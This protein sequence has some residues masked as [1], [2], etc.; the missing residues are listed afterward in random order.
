LYSEL[1]HGGNHLQYRRVDCAEDME[2][3]LTEG[4]WDIVISDHSM[5]R[6]S[7]TE[8][9][10][11]LQAS[12]KDIP[13]IIYSGD[14]KESI[15]VTAMREGV[16][17]YIQKGNLARLMPVIERELKGAEVRRAKR[18]AES[19]VRQLEFYDELTGLPNRHMLCMSAENALEEAKRNERGLAIFHIDLDRF[20]RINNSFG[21]ATGD[22]LLRRVGLRLAA[23]IAVDDCIAR[24]SGDTF[25]LMSPGA[26]DE[27][28]SNRTVGRIMDAFAE[29]FEVDGIEFFMSLSIGISM[30]P[31]GGEDVPS[32]LVNAETAMALAK[33]LGGGNFKYYAKD[34]NAAS[35]EWLTLESSLRHAVTRGQLRLHYQP[36]ID[37]ASGDIVGVE[38]LVRWQHPQHGLLY[39]DSFIPLAD[40]TG[41][42]TEIGE[43]VLEA[44]CRQTRAWHALGFDGLTVAVNVS[45]VQ[46]AQRRLID[47][48][49][50]VLNTTGLPPH[51]LVLE[52]TESTLMEDAA[53]NEATLIELKQMGIHIAMDDFGTGYSSLSYLKRFPIDILKIDKSFIRDVGLEGDDAAIVRAIVALGKSLRLTLIGEG[54]ETAEQLKFLANEKCD[55]VQGY[56]FSK[57]V[58]GEAVAG[59][60]RAGKP[61]TE[62]RLA[63]T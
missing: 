22:A 42:I 23:C 1:A 29:P 5:P 36:C 32:M 63:L 11:I 52:I 30:Y 62:R 12:G 50:N 31:E 15:A 3:A 33:K 16:Q 35:S 39:P 6:F 18:L 40:E 46:F 61:V 44:A 58:S 8:A 48:V 60:L 20:M 51:A 9:Y 47:H 25:V 14:I 24:V 53:A 19:Q 27:E 34:M 2:R 38:A 13:F 4:D 37:V 10:K 56:L 49:A 59:M 28:T 17:D 7:S 55:H 41:L 21:Y 57:P 45:A 43:W 26:V 54:V